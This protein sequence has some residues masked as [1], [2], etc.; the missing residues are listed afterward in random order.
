MSQSFQINGLKKYLNFPI[1][2]KL[3]K[4]KISMTNDIQ[5]LNTIYSSKDYFLKDSYNDVIKNI[6]DEKVDKIFISEK[7]NQA[8][9]VFKDDIL[10]SNIF[11]HYHTVTVNKVILPNLLDKALE[12]NVY[13]SFVDFTPPLISWFQGL[14][15][16]L[17][18]FLQIAFPIYIAIV[19]ISGIVNLSNNG[20]GNKKGGN[21]L[22]LF[23]GN[24]M[25]N[26]IVD[27]DSLTNSSLNE[28]IGSPEVIEEVRDVISYLSKKEEYKKIG[29]EMPKG[30]LLEGPPGTG[31]TLLAKAIAFETNS[32]F[33]SISGS[34][35]VEV[36]VGVGASK[37]RKLFESAR[38]NAPSIIFIDEIDAIG[39]Q[40]GNSASSSNGANDEREQTLNQILYEM[41]GFNKNDDI[42]VMGATNRKDVLDQALLRPG[43]FDRIIRI[44]LPDKDS[45]E[46]ILE[47]YLNNKKKEITIDI[48]AIADLTNGF[49]G[50]QLK[51]LINEAAILSVRNNYT[52]IKENFIYDSFE[53]SAVGLLRNNLKTDN[54]TISRV[55][56]HEIGHTLLVLKFK[57]YFDFKKVSIQS[58]YNGAGGYTLFTEKPSIKNEGLYTK[59]ILKKRLIIAMGGKAAESIYYGDEFVSLGATQD[60]NQANKLAKQMI[61][62]YGMGDKLQV[63]Y[64]DP[65]ENPFSDNTYSEE[66]KT[67]I[68]VETLDLVKEAYIEAKNILSN[69]TEYFIFLCDLLKNQ[70]T[71]SNKELPYLYLF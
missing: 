5:D 6:M 49:S 26:K 69:N 3:N 68:D 70:T 42:I 24:N 60:L 18:Q 65:E 21:N 52:V 34:E 45:R 50:A 31:K 46:K 38:D 4:M 56:I 44:P 25:D 55:T 17:G 2:N 7:S 29:A 48:D 8:I 22:N 71:I 12:K 13:I 20:D 30:I 67:L 35:F 57:E 11:H 54:D 61:C 15:S 23:G 58:T 19:I 62:N 39:K 43:R 41:D 10:N 63:F 64:K 36:F 37:V 9:E 1:K 33:F 51:N 32:A 53:K 47:F 14:A 28:W 59:D 66:T 16:N 40:R 27:K